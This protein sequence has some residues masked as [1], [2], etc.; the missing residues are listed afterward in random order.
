MDYVVTVNITTG[1]QVTSWGGWLA[2]SLLSSTSSVAWELVL[3]ETK[4][5][6]YGLYSTFYND[7]SFIALCLDCAYILFVK[8]LKLVLRKYMLWKG[9][10]LLVFL[11]VRIHFSS[12]INNYNNAIFDTPDCGENYHV[13][14]Y[15]SNNFMIIPV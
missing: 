13:L 14:F 2:V 4:H 8:L 11:G 9:K 5:C 12:L 7:L 10:L 1:C 6:G 15:R 3:C